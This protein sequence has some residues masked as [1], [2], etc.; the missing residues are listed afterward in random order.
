MKAK[1]IIA[2]AITVALMA[3][4]IS[5]N[6]RPAC[7][8][9]QPQKDYPI[10]IIS[11][12][13]NG[14]KDDD[15]S[16]EK[17]NFSLGYLQPGSRVS[18]EIEAVGDF[19]D[20]SY[21]KVLCG[22]K[23]DPT[24]INSDEVLAVREENFKFTVIVPDAS[25]GCWM[26]TWPL[27]ISK[28]GKIIG[29]ANTRPVCLC[30]DFM[31]PNITTG[32]A[33]N[34]TSA[35]ATLNGDMWYAGNAPPS[36]V[37]F[38]L[39]EENQEYGAKEML[40]YQLC[41]ERKSF[42]F[43]IQGLK[44]S[45]RYYFRAIGANYAGISEAQE[46]SFQTFPS[47]AKVRTL[48][49]SDINMS[50][51]VSSWEELYATLN[52]E[53][54]DHGHSSYLLVGWY[55]RDK[56]ENNRTI[57]KTEPCRIDGPFAEGKKISFS[58]KINVPDGSATYLFQAYAVNEIGQESRGQEM[59]FLAPS[60]SVPLEVKTLRKKGD[61]DWHTAKLYL[62]LKTLGR[63]NSCEVW[64]DYCQADK[65][66]DPIGP[67]QKSASIVVENSGIYFITLENFPSDRGLGPWS[68]WQRNQSPQEIQEAGILRDIP[69]W[70]YKAH[71]RNNAGQE[72]VDEPA[73]CR[74]CGKPHYFAFGTRFH[75]E[76]PI[77]KI[78]EIGNITHTEADLNLVMFWPGFDTHIE[79][80]AEYWGFDNKTFQ[81]VKFSQIIP[82]E[83]YSTLYMGADG[84]YNIF[85]L[86][87]SGLKPASWYTVR[88]Y[89]TNSSGKTAV[90]KMARF[91]TKY[92]QE[93][94]EYTGPKIM[95]I[96]YDEV[97]AGNII[98]QGKLIDSGKSDWV[99]CWLEFYAYRTRNSADKTIE[100]LGIFT[101]SE[102]LGYP[103]L[104]V[105]KNGLV[106]DGTFSFR[107]VAENN[108]GQRSY[109]EVKEFQT[110]PRVG[111]A[112][113]P[114]LRAEIKNISST[115]FVVEGYL[116][117]VGKGTNGQPNKLD[118]WFE[119]GSA[120]LQEENWTF[121]TEFK[122]EIWTGIGQPQKFQWVVNDLRPGGRYGFQIYANA[123]SVFAR[124]RGNSKGF[125]YI[126]D[127]PIIPP[128]FRAL[129][130]DF[131]STTTAL[132]NVEVTYPSSTGNCYFQI[133]WGKVKKNG[134]GCDFEYKMPYSKLR[135]DGYLGD[136]SLVRGFSWEAANLEPDTW[137]AF[138]V[139]ARPVAVV[140]ANQ[141]AFGYFGPYYSNEYPFKTLKSAEDP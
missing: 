14:I 104:A 51:W 52:L 98:M 94:E 72:Y 3:T 76:S 47:L 117:S 61:V 135:S 86:H 25:K 44:A 7:A 99:K 57:H 123:K 69:G 28:S 130:P 29:S 13:I 83:G 56:H 103:E 137:Y 38:Q 49:A 82:L 55:W 65:A 114:L 140:A 30:F 89:A 87:L 138:R 37:W 17:I 43:E 62:E 115:G 70:V 2:M 134:Q 93:T 23:N 106:T 107:F 50:E 109:G 33:E 88:L 34:I 10:K 53:I 124:G 39:R 16:Q 80:W 60:R 9:T 97:S 12:T 42:A 74:A 108:I 75:A 120:R 105:E 100:E 8:L 6:C 136:L 91:R 68:W 129:K 85:S 79:Y 133:E 40:G 132:L 31:K 131:I 139:V 20:F 112:T 116:E 110:S 26:K 67:W 121:R 48:P 95:T 41:E 101:I 21:F 36:F 81:T 77:I 66:G 15:A 27:A 73:F 64:F 122:S 4:A 125:V 11:V 19:S 71:A 119:G 46:Q 127:T 118:I 84:K 58:K 126:L 54:E 59:Y 18:Y 141:E 35:S 78:G 32:R 24:L 45:T 128:E 90:S 1:I 113:R 111:Q 5:G 102:N 22:R 63:G 92:G 96:G